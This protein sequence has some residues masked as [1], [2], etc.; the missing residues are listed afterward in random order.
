MFEG[1]NKLIDLITTY[2]KP[3]PL[4][5]SDDNEIVPP[6]ERKYSSHILAYS[7]TRVKW[8]LKNIYNKYLNDKWWLNEC[9][10]YCGMLPFFFVFL[11]WLFYTGFTVI[12]V[13]SAKASYDMN[14]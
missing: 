14:P 9:R 13:Q 8:P 12:K 7:K 5:D 4:K 11:G 3:F 6:T 2:G 1:D 10:K